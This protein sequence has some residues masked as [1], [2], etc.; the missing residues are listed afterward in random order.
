MR[1]KTL[2]PAI[3][4]AALLIPGLAM[5]DGKEGAWIHIEVTEDGEDGAKVKV[6][7]PL[8]LAAM[9]LEMAPDE[10]FS[11]GRIQIEDT[12]ITV[13]QMRE[14]WNELRDVGDAEFVTIEED[15][16]IVR[17][18]REGEWLLVNV[19]QLGYREFLKLVV[20]DLVQ[21]QTGP[22]AGRNFWLRGFGTDTD[23]EGIE[24]L[25]AELEL[26]TESTK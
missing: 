19:T 1:W 14:L 25:M 15:D 22:W 11:D 10:V 9:A 7:L 16:E 20:G 17:V 24:H 3:L 6:N 4:A 21:G 8:S 26:T 5:A 13:E 18:S 12:D 2:F 23:V